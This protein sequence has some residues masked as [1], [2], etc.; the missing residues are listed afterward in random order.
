MQAGMLAVSIRAPS[1]RQVRLQPLDSPQGAA[2][3]L[4]DGNWS[5]KTD[6]RCL[7][8]EAYLKHG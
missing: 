7:T 5:E 1:T 3:L 6:L 8:G 4:P 2:N